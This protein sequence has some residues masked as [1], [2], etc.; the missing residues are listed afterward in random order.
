M[1]VK[2]RNEMDARDQWRLEDMFES[3][4]VW[5]EEFAVAQKQ[6][7]G[8]AGYAGTLGRGIEQFKEALDAQSELALRVERLFVYAHMRRDEDNACAKFQGMA[9]RAMGLSVNFSSSAS[10]FVPE[11]MEIPGETLDLWRWDERLKTYAH[12]L[13]DIVRMR[14]HTLS[15]AEERLLAM[16]GEVG[17]A[18]QN[19]YKMLDNA[20]I[21]FPTIRVKDG[22]VEISHGN[23]IHLM[24]SGER[25]V[26]KEA[27][28]KFY[29]TYE[30]FKNTYAAT[31]SS[32]VKNDVF[33]AK[34]RNYPSALG[35]SLYQDAVPETVYD[36]LIAAIRQ[37]LPVLH[38]YMALRKRVLGLDELHFYDLYAPLSEADYAVGYDEAKNMVLDGLRPLGAEYGGL[39][40]EAFDGRWV[41]VY[42][43]RG[44]TSGAYCWGAYGTHPFV[45]LNYQPN[46]D[47]VFTI[48]HE[49]GHALHSY[50][51]DEAQDYVNAQYKIL[52]AE[53]ASTVNEALLM[54]H[55]LNTETDKARLLRLL[56]YYLEQFRT[57]VYR[58]VMFAEFEKT[59]HEHVEA[60]GALTAENIE[61]MYLQL[62]R[63]YYGEEMVMDAGI[64]MEWAR[65]SHF[66]NA[67]YV[68]KYATGFSAAVALSSAIL[69]EGEGAV[70]RY[71]AFLRSGGSDYPLALLQNAGV[72]LTRSQAVGG[73]LD[74][75][76]KT[77]SRL[78]A[79]V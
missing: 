71:L 39:L 68:Y 57:T 31:L 50:Y 62:N 20:D 17:A 32:S 9:D 30:G 56:N 12:T 14:A 26:R 4:G 44:K 70:K 43:N 8:F 23:Y 53:V 49:M 54:E 13:D 69:K 3:D 64:S 59:I 41:D 33:G 1:N 78:E 2:N 15:H 63:D 19:I 27:F 6:C 28:E 74:V 24:Q 45:L 61:Q 42:E 51:S 48:A 38:R 75:F 79:L 77:L 73:A 7:G 60:G 47:S 58:Q 16:S 40:R 67:F 37:K 11:I 65:I 5:E 76:E 22:E 29:G 25:A 36:S 72:D 10:F 46:I 55:L 34:V 66:Y 52:V 35:A 21:R 18:P